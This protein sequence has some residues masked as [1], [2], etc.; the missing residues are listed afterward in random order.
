MIN[1]LFDRAGPSE[2]LSAEQLGK[3]EVN[4]LPAEP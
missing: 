2:T 1:L 3:I 4:I